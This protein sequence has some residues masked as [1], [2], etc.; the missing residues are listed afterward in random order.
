LN[1]NYNNPCADEVYASPSLMKLPD[2]EKGAPLSTVATPTGSAGTIPTADFGGADCSSGIKGTFN[3]TQVPGS[4]KVFGPSGST[5]GNVAYVGQNAPS[6]SGQCT[7]TVQ[8]SFAI[9]G[10]GSQ[11]VVLAWGGHIANFHDWGTGN[12]ASAI[13]GSPYHMALDNLD[14]VT[15][16]SQDRALATS[17]VFFPTTTAT[18]LSSGSISVGQT[19]SDT[20]IVSGAAPTAAGSVAFTVYSEN[21]CTTKATT[22]SGGQINAQPTQASFTNSSGTITATSS[23]VTFQQAGNY[24]WQ[25]IYS[26][27]SGT[28][29][30]SSMSACTS[31]PLTVGSPSVSVAKTTTTPKVNAG[32]I[33]NYTVTV[34][35]SS[36]LFT[37]TNV[38]VTDTLPIGNGSDLSWSITAGDSTNCSVSSGVLS[39]TLATLAP[40]GSDSVTVSTATTTADCGF[41][42]NQAT[43]TS[44]N[45][46]G[47]TT[48]QVQIEVD[49]PTT[50]ATQLSQTTISTGGSVSDQATISGAA[51]TAGG[52]ITYQVFN[53]STCSGTPTD[54]T[55][56]NN[57]VVGGVA[58]ASK[59]ITFTSGG[60]FYWYAIYS[61]DPGTNTGGSNS[62]CASEPLTVLS[63]AVSIAKTT[64]TPK[65][66]AGTTIDYTLTVSNSGPGTASTF[67]VTDTLPTN[68]GTNWSILGTSAGG[69]STFSCAISSGT[70]TCSGTN[71]PPTTSS[72]TPTVEVS[73]PTTTATCGFVNNSAT[74]T[75]G[76]DGGNTTGQVQIE[77][78]CPTLTT[79]SLSASAI[80][81]GKTVSDTS[82]TTGAS[83]SAS[84]T[85]TFA[86]Y[87]NTACTT[88][89]TTGTTGQIDAQ[90]TSGPL[91]NNAGTITAASSNVKFQ[92]AGTYY[93]LATYSGDTFHNTVGSASS[94]T[95]EVETVFGPCTIG[96]PST[97]TFNEST[98]T[99]AV[100]VEGSGTGQSIHVITND[101]S[102]LL[103][104]VNGASADSANGTAP[105]YTDVN[106][107]S[108]G[109]ATLD[110][111]L[112]PQYPAL[113][114]TDITSDQNSTAGDWQSRAQTRQISDGITTGGS[115][116]FSVPSTSSDPPFTST[117]VGKLISD[118]ASKNAI[119]AG[120]TIV[121]INSTK[122]VVMSAKATSNQ[123]GDV[124]I[125]ANPPQPANLD[126]TT[127]WATTV[128]G[129]WATATVSGTTYTAVR[130][131]N[132]N[133]WNF[134]PNE[135]PVAPWRQITDATETL[136]ST[137]LTT[138]FVEFSPAD[139][140][141][142]IDDA[143]GSKVIPAGTTIT[144]VALN[145]KSVTLSKAATGAHTGDTVAIGSLGSVTYTQLLGSTGNEGFGSD[146]G[147]SVS[148]SNGHVLMAW[149]PTKNSYVPLA[150]GH[151][152]RVQVMTHDGDQNKTGGDVGQFC[153]NVI[154]PSTTAGAS[155]ATL[156][157]SPVGTPTSL[158]AQ[159]IDRIRSGSVLAL[160]TV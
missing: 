76:N 31:E 109:S 14:G 52:T 102:G 113:F 119:P 104:G 83:P 100:I 132:K 118:G 78:D 69:A 106:N 134:G 94:C 124:T 75:S 1:A 23:P 48:G 13:S 4:V 142:P 89:A 6:G 22:G 43:V 56:A 72:T 9:G 24:F 114:I 129:S 21:T 70:L 54:A 53:N 137:T 141:A 97:P 68:S 63:P 154:V 120:T 37:A 45:D 146:V 105:F 73:S 82:T 79:T 20:A 11:N 95:S 155:T 15:L 40:L 71:L 151:A 41:V 116:T 153:A 19:V 156:L 3:G 123:T 38:K 108:L 148:G 10:S 117:D 58:P 139:V 91:T 107:P 152:Y 86:I 66:N 28:N 145:G 36:S 110:P 42:N 147:W 150:T 16:G 128:G 57:A 126:G 7:T 25:A 44:G 18:T 99:R 49:C 55:P 135:D 159:F 60:T 74:V 122:S 138:T 8:I 33:I 125:I 111:T 5:V 131:T 32:A 34:T 98:V 59:S 29:T 133:N 35:N 2:C 61:G 30:L 80:Q 93:W 127:P 90:P 140:G 143:N 112:R 121:S 77:V 115:F 96:F 103:L 47:N 85:V 67:T 84:G 157:S 101:E 62:G 92:L 144:A 158:G 130:P 160:G 39:C 88:F 27:D 81:V 17:A 64:D 50:L 12:S 149:D 51:P 136:N 26:G 46:G 65:V 87:T